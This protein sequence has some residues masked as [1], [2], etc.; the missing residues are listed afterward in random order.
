MD[1]ILN[2]VG[3]NSKDRNINDTYKKYYVGSFRVF[4]NQIGFEQ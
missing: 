2:M 1:K 4:N 3:G